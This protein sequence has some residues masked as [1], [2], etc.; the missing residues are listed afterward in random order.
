MNNV[1]TA[2][3]TPVIIKDD[4]ECVKY[5]PEYQ[6]MTAYFT[7]EDFATMASGAQ[8]DVEFL[9]SV[10]EGMTKYLRDQSAFNR[11][12]SWAAEATAVCRNATA[13]Y[14]EDNDLHIVF[15]IGVDSNQVAD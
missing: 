9:N 15:L 5:S 6:S 2:V 13:D 4:Q 3:I 7:T 1:P 10:S 12:L 14:R 11:T 8:L